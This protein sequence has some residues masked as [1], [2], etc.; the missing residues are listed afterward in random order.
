MYRVKIHGAGSIGNHLANASRVMG[1]SVDICDTDPAALERTR[2]R[3]YPERYGK[4]DDAIRLF[5]SKEAPQGG[6]DLVFI[7]TP[8]SSHLE[9]AFAALREKPR[10]VLIEKPLCPPDLSQ[11]Q[12][13]HLASKASGARVFV[14]YNHVIAP[15]LV[16]LEAVLRGQGLGPVETLDVEFREHW[17]GIF[18]AHPWL[19]GPADS[20]LGFW[21]R[22]GGASGEHSHAIN[23]WQ[24]LA[25]VLGSGR[26][27]EVSATMDFV[28][29]SGADYD[30][31]C[32]FHLK[33]ESGLI[34]RCVQDVVTKPSRKWGRV[35]GRDGYAEFHV[36]HKPGLDL[37]V[38][39]SGKAE[40]TERPFPKT[41]PDDFIVELKHIDEILS[42]KRT[43][44]PIDLERGLDTMLAIVAAHRSA[45]EGRRVT[46]DYTK[47]YGPDAIV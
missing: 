6:Y 37:V 44:S 21:N 18:A 5:A 19:N 40:P 13:L 38:H 9:L 4:W 23:L 20:Y 33:T 28:R 24:H 12:E 10:A 8:P 1:W 42:G 31:T 25:R 36:N 41:R 3:I 26:V 17:G 29:D 32:G 27:V 39:A 14:G 47:G 22:G 35:Q 15:A 7:G 30:K 43:D 46:I 11:T 34:G 45:R 2:Q 16:E